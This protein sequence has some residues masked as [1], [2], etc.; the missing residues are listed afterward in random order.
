MK[1]IRSLVVCSSLALIPAAFAQRWEV[2]GGVGGGFYNSHDVSSPA[3]SA[4][5]KIQP[6]VAGSAWIGNTGRGHLGGELRFDYQLGDLQLSQGST[7]TT[8]GASSYAI[9]YDV[10]W[11]FADS[12]ARVRP[13]VSAGG[14]VKAYR[15]T[16]TEAAF[17]PL[18]SYA[19]LTKEQDLTGLVSI[20]GG[21]KVALSPHMQLRLEVHDY[22]TPFPKKVI[23]PAANS[24]ISGWMQ[25][26]VPMVGLAYTF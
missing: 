3:G 24:S 12:E 16:G 11:H 4:S 21:V 14:G 23:T 19:L 25:D 15:G 1:L 8:F 6:N 2:G 22:L 18:S 7:Q 9:H 20:G 13:F 10:L 5:T 26:F 17:Q